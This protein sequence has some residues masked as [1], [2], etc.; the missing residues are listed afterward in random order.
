MADAYLSPDYAPEAAA[1]RCGVSAKKIR[2]IAAELA[3]VA[4]EEAVVLER[5][6]TDFRGDT[7]STMVGRPV[8][9]HAISTHSNGFQTCRALHVLQIILGTVATLG[10]FRF[11]LPYPKPHFKVT[12]GKPLDGPHLGFVHC[13]EDL[14]LKEDGSHARIDKAF[15]WDNPMSAHG[16]MH[17]V[18]PKILKRSTRSLCIWRTCL[19]TRR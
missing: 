17:M 10:G 3:R 16:L 8:S 14:A 7:H 18:I 19:G 9:M 2:T 5:E 1:E 11:K 15:T 13:P 6:W 12:S 4:F